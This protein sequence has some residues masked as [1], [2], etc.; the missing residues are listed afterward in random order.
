M[1]TEASELKVRE[2][3]LRRVAA[4]QGLFLSRRRRRDHNALDFGRY[5]LFRGGLDGEVM[6]GVGFGGHYGLT[7]RDVEL[8]LAAGEEKDPP[9]TEGRHDSGEETETAPA[10]RPRR[11]LGKNRKS[12]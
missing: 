3:R 7:L 10:R 4:R 12:R 1:S 9:V 6:A 5:A 8:I 11:A 2:N